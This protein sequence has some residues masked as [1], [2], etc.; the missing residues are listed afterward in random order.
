MVLNLR[1]CRTVGSAPWSSNGIVKA[2][3]ARS[4]GSH[5]LQSTDPSYINQLLQLFDCNNFFGGPDAGLE[6]ELLRGSYF[7]DFGDPAVS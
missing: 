5:V 3:P 4:A 1:L 6:L 2:V 7:G